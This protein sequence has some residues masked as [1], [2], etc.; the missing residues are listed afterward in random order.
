M[1]K[2]KKELFVSPTIII[3]EL[4]DNDFIITTSGDAQLPIYPTD[5]VEE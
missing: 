3:I 5:D 4:S 1:N 2:D